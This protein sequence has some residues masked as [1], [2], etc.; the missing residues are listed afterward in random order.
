MSEMVIFIL[1]STHFGKEF[2]EFKNKEWMFK[3]AE[4]EPEFILNGILLG[5]DVLH[6]GKNTLC[7]S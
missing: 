7:R 1:I 3:T 6:P 2:I 4:I 5:L